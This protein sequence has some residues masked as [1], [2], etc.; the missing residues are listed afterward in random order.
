MA[1][2][3][4]QKAFHQRHKRWSDN[5]GELKLKDSL[6]GMRMFQ[7]DDGYEVVLDADK[8]GTTYHVRQDSRLWKTS[9]N[10]DTSQAIK[11]ILFE[12]AEAWNRGNLDKF[13]EYYWNSDNLT[14]SSSGKTTRG[15]QTTKDNYKRR[16]PTRERMGKLS[17]AE[18]EV[19]HLN[20]KAALVLGRWNL[21][22]NPA[23]ISGNFSLV[24]RQ[25]DDCWLIVHDHTSVAAPG[26]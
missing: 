3:H 19:V 20:N 24:F 17:F 23:P 6:A 22:R 4:H 11:A 18:L 12:Q 5:L 7:T 25:I 10:D 15:W 1:V 21:E 16:Y 9:M 13:M 8:S 2:Y 14:F 26:A